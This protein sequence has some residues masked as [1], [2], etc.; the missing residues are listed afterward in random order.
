LGPR[1]RRFKSCRSDHSFNAAG[2]EESESP[3]DHQT[4]AGGEQSKDSPNISEGFPAES[5][6]AVTFPKRLRFNNRGKPLAVIYRR[7]DGY[8]LYWR[9]RSAV[10]GKP[11]SHMVDFHSYREAKRRGDQV[12]KDL[13]KSRASGLTPG[14]AT[15]AVAAFK[16]LQAF[17]ESTGKR[18]SLLESV[19]GYCGAVRRLGDR[20]VGEAIDA[21]LSTVATVKRVDLLQAVEEWIAGRKPK[22]VA[23]QGKRPQLSAGYAYT[24]AMYLREF[25]NTFQNHAVCELSKE[26]LDT[27]IGQHSDVG[28]KSRNERRM[29]LKMFLK[30]AV[31]KDYLPASHRLFEAVGMKPE[32]A[33]PGDIEPYTAEELRVMLERASKRPE[34]PKEGQEPEADYR[35]LLPIIALIALGGVRLQEATRLTLEDVWHVEGHIEVSV[36]KSKTRSRRLATMCPALTAWLESCRDKTGPLWTQ[37]LDHFHRAFERM[38][39]ELEIPVRRNGL[40]HGFCTYHYALHADEGLTA[41]EA[42]NSPGVVHSNYKGLATKK[43]GEAWFA[44]AP[45]QPDNVVQLGKVVTK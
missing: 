44:V 39:G 40:R 20:P 4:E 28:P 16:A 42:G 15:D 3:D 2:I 41:K 13:A 5:E 34:P 22:T 25:A 43:Q 10:D 6:H 21:F 35:H 27:Y 38:L 17:Y 1:R 11:A 37:C 36:A 18:L 14:Q 8:R 26:L 32:G 9:L 19:M 29:T 12:V 23:K 24:C 7:A 30:W 31:A 45:A 33:E